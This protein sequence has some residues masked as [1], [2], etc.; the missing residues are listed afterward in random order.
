MKLLLLLWQVYQD[1]NTQFTKALQVTM[2][3]TAQNSGE[4]YFNPEVHIIKMK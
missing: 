2:N 1:K 3:T 4:L